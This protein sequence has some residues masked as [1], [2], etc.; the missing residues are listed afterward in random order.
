[1]SDASMKEVHESIMLLDVTQ[2]VFLCTS[3]Q[4]ILCRNRHLLEY[5][6]HSNKISFVV[7]DEIHLVNHFG[8]TFRSEFGLLKQAIF[9][10]LPLVTP[11]MYMTATCTAAICKSFQSLLGVTLICDH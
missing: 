6:I 1:M 9:E 4:C 5:L 8:K 3:P 2:T 11:M 7:I 10:C